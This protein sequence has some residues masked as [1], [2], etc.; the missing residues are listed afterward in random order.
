DVIGNLVRHQLELEDFPLA[1]MHGDLHTRNIMVRRLKRSENPE[2]DN[3][4]DFKLI[5]LEKFRRSGDAA[6][7]AGELLVD[8]EILRATRNNDP[9]R[10]PHAAL[11][12]A[13]EQT[14]ADFAAEREDKTFAIRMQL[15]QARSIIR[16][17]KGRTKQ[18]EL[19]LKES[20]KGHAI[21][22]ALD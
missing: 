11:I 10:D 2:R 3:E 12:H 16:I 6:L 7:D 4:I 21:R 17:A 5:D 14:Y 8:L 22:V 19:S 13:V 20:R 9:A 18:G 1:C 15:G